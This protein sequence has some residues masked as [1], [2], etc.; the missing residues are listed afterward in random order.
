MILFP[1]TDATDS[2]DLQVNPVPLSIIK[3]SFLCVYPDFY[4][5][6]RTLLECG[7]LNQYTDTLLYWKAELF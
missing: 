3:Q 5:L 1:D 7:L 2:V 4:L 6:F